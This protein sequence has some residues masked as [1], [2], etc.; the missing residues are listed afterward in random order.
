[1][2]LKDQTSSVIVYINVIWS[3]KFGDALRLP[4]NSIAIKISYDKKYHQ[5]STDLIYIV[6][7]F[8]VDGTHV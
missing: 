4:E 3:I 7:L 2:A 8:N 5:N 1:M 6:L